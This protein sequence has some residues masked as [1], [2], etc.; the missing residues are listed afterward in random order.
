MKKS[1]NNENSRDSRLIE[2]FLEM[3]S[4]ER[5]AARNTLDAYQRDL[6]FY[7]AFLNAAGAG[8]QTAQPEHIRNYLDALDAEGLKS[9]SAARRLSAVR[10]FHNFLYGEGIVR[11]NPATALDAPRMR[12]GRPRAW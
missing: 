3:M 5:G 2:R 12:R 8:L 10:Q 1:D 6:S 7:S 9:S 11:E 4:A